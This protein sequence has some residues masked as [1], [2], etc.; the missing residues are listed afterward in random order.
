[1]MQLDALLLL[2]GAIPPR[3]AKITA[4]T[5]AAVFD[6][7]RLTLTRKQAVAALMERADASAPAAYNALA[8]D[9]RFAAQLKDSGGNLTWKPN[10]ETENKQLAVAANS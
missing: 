3:M 10:P 5:M 8:P 7:G 9:G 6:G 2:A 1:M 4:E